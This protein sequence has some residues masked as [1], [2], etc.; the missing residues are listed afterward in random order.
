M[1]KWFI[2]AILFV[3]HMIL[4]G[5]CLAIGFKLG[6]IAMDKADKYIK[7]KQKENDP[8]TTAV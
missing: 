8:V 6:Y 3:F 5:L 1:F 4:T 2:V 7:D